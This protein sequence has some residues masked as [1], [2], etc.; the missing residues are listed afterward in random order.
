MA[1]II[2]RAYTPQGESSWDRVFGKREERFPYYGSR[3]NIDG[4]GKPITELPFLGSRYSWE[5]VEPKEKIVE[6]HIELKNNNT[7]RVI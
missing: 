6:D 2:S 7:N 5:L 3:G 1:D 4:F